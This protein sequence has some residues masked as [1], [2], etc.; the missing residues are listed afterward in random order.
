MLDDL[1]L[2]AALDQLT[3]E[4][5]EETGIELHCERVIDGDAPPLPDS[6]N[7]ALFRIAQEALTN[8]VRHAAAR[9]ATLKLEV[10]PK[11]VVLSIRDDGRGFDVERMQA[12]ARSGIGLRNMRE[13]LD[14]IGGTLSL[15]SEPGNTI[16]TATVPLQRPPAKIKT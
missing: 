3:R 5:K 13:R 14:A 7:T 10:A 6:I 1:G 9:Q 8:V 4:L 12:D 11:S 15:S 2:A 16:V